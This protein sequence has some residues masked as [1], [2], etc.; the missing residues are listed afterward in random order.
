M[1][2]HIPKGTDWSNVIEIASLFSKRHGREDNSFI[3]GLFPQIRAGAGGPAFEPKGPNKHN[4]NYFT[5]TVDATVMDSS[6]VQVM[7]DHNTNDLPR[8]PLPL[9]LMPFTVS[10]S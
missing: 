3:C 10:W 4:S 2:V 9:Y 5:L 1:N 8:K 6:E 7:L